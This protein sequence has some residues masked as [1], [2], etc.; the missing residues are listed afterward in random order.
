MSLTSLPYEIVHCSS[1][2]DDYSPEQLAKSS[3]GNQLDSIPV[4]CKGWQTPK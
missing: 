3:P 4:K 1:F 2:D